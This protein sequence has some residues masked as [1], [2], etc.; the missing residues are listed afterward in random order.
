MPD[1][2]PMTPAGK[3]RLEKA[4]EELESRRPE[5]QRAIAEA[6]EKGDLSENAEYHAAREALGQLEARIA[7]LR[8]KLARAQVV[9]L[10]RAPKDRVAFGAS[11]KLLNLDTGQ[12]ENYE[13]VGAGEDDVSCGRI[14]TTS[15]LGQ[16]LLRRKVGEE[17]EVDAPGGK[18]R[19]RV[20]EIRYP[21]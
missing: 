2:V 5:I 11:V 7:E 9:D 6:R 17:V 13:L 1:F 21:V 20:L 18:I 14:L 8:D 3:Q 12:Q 15:P 10:R 16:A 4:L 19:F